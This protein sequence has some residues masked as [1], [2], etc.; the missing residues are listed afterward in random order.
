MS[1]ELAA[2]LVGGVGLFLLGMRLMTEGL[3]LSAGHA[4]REV[5]ARSTRTRLRGIA[6][7]VL[8]TSLVQSSS[9]ITVATIG[10][11]NAGL[12][13][14]G[15]ALAVTYGS[16]VGTTA[17]G[18]LVAAVGLHVNVHAFALPLIG[19]G[20]AMRLLA[21]RG[22]LGPLGDALAG[23]G[24]FFLGI[25]ALHSGFEGLSGQIELA[26]LAG[27]GPLRVLLFVAVGFGLT[28]LMQSSSAAIALVLTAAGGGVV[29]LGSGA[30]LVIGANLGTTSTAALAVIGATPNAKRVA[31]GHVAFNA[32]TGAVALLLLPFL[33]LAIVQGR[34]LLELDAGP[35]AVLAAFHTLFNL[36]GVAIMLPLTGRLLRELEHRFRTTEEDDAR[37]RYLDRNIV[38]TPDLA[39][40]A[41]VLELTR[42]GQLTRR[43]TE[44]ALAG[45]RDAPRAV[46]AG[47]LAHGRL[48]DAIGDYTELLQ[49]A[50]LP[51]KLATSLAAALRALRNYSEAAELAVA[52]AEGRGVLVP[53][54]DEALDEARRGFVS[55][56]GA[57]IRRAGIELDDYDADAC[58][59]QAV[60][61]KEGYQSLKSCLLDAGSRGL[62]P[63][64]DL[65]E[66][67]D[68]LSNVRRAA[69]Q[70]ERGTRRLA[71]VV[72]AAEADDEGDDEA[73][74]KAREPGAAER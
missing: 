36:L 42:V 32:I 37:P 54:K 7:G 51:G 45:D 48:V 58:A 38:A 63:V 4:L 60:R 19:I 10:F 44:T 22:R 70:V 1:I 67:L 14:L 26:S 23:F 29:P 27:A 24:L 49:G 56:A 59:E 13:T 30:A 28:L 17:T 9:A 71:A 8:V 74:E 2:R 15:Q 31:A 40:G 50:S 65:V 34:E 69:E 43:L 11:V 64:H 25:D 61:L 66:L 62:V 3:K 18:W 21:S 52:I 46:A 6:S 68:W 53:P 35:A 41:M 12:L 57:L 73:A 20:M 5:L 72:A 16:N 55:D 33:L 47:Q 39:V